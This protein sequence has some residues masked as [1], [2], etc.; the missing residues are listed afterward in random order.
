[1]LI[2]IIIWFNLKTTPFFGCWREPVWTLKKWWSVLFFCC[3]NLLGSGREWWGMSVRRGCVWKVTR[4]GGI[5]R[6]PALHFQAA[7][8]RGFSLLGSRWAAD[9]AENPVDGLEL[10]D[11]CHP[12]SIFC[13]W[14]RRLDMRGKPSIFRTPDIY[15]TLIVWYNVFVLSLSLSLYLCT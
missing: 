7:I 1:M 8:F 13:T 2:Y 9:G 6:F 15:C 10:A 5:F 3:N 4:E 11:R 12:A 14:F